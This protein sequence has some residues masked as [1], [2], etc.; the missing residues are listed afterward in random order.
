V[1]DWLRSVAINVAEANSPVRLAQA[2][3]SGLSLDK[4]VVLARLWR[5]EESSGVLRLAGS[6]GTPS[7]GGSYSRLDGE[8]SVI[9]MG[10]GKIGAIASTGEARIVRGLRGDEDWLA[11]ST[12]VSRQGVKTFVGLPLVAGQAVL[13]VFALF[14]RRMLSDQYL[15]DLR[16]IVDLTAAR[17][18]ALPLE[19]ESASSAVPSSASSVAAS[20]AR[21]AAA[22]LTRDQLRAFEKANIETAL[23]QTGGKIFGEDGAARLLD[24]RPTT[25][26]SRIKALGIVF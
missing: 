11:N 17:L 2:V 22:V 9:A 15:D 18:A 19:R 24:M 8:F 23:A 5:L 4:A 13:G 26:A 16:F 1:T 12:W 25:L 20:S 7:G 21:S 6:A 14:D 3:A 10:A